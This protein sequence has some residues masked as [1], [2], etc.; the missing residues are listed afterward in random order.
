MR[1]LSD[2]TE[3]L[4][5]FDES[6]WAFVVLEESRRDDE[7]LDRMRVLLFLDALKGAGVTA[8]SELAV[9]CASGSWMAIVGIGERARVP[10]GGVMVAALSKR[11][12]L[13]L[14]QET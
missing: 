11:G 9:S 7:I 8:E 5:C 1:S 10:V 14:S 4:P 12:C 2:T 6:V 13:G 3:V